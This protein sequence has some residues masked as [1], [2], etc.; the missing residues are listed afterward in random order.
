MKIHT[1]Q[2]VHDGDAEVVTSKRAISALTLVSLAHGI[3]HAQGALKPLVFPLVLREL[4][5]GYSELGI[6]LGVASAVG[7][8][9]QLG[10]GALGRVI[11]RHHI[12]GLGNASVGICFVLVG[13]AQSYFQFF[14]W[15]VMSRV[16]GAAQHPVGSSLLS[17]HFKKRKL[18]TAL[19]THFTAGNIGTAVIPLCAAILIS[20]WGWRGTVILFAVP[21]ILVGLAMSI[22][23]KDP[24]TEKPQNVTKAS[25]FW[26]DSG[27]VIGDRN[28]RWVL[29]AAIVAAGGSGHGIISSFLP[30]YLNHNL[31]MDATARRH[32]HAHEYRQYLWSDARRETSRSISPA[33]HPTRRISAIGVNDVDHPLARRELCGHRPG[34]ITPWSDGVWHPSYST[35]AGCSYDF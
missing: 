8:L 16:G 24:A 23:L 35:D 22:W 15:T 17:H 31:G 5:F 27:Q 34:R 14:F 18:G 21:A 19:A 9:L 29:V 30:L 20:L 6:M 2:H 13:L 3:N 7:G 28:L 10:A 32:F 12:L 11:P 4:N 33:A 26:Q 1:H 25:S